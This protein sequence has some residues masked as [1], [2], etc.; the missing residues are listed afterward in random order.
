MFLDNLHYSGI[1]NLLPAK[2]EF[3]STL[4]LFW[5]KNGAGKTSFLEAVHLLATGKSFRANA[6]QEYLS[7]NEE[8]CLLSGI[9][10]TFNTNL[11]SVRL[12]IERFRDG[13][14]TLRIAEEK[15]GSLAEFARVLAV[16][17]MSGDSYRLFDELPVRRRRFMDWGMF[18][19]E[20]SFFSHWQRYH[21]AL[22]QRNRALKTFGKRVSEVKAWDEILI[23]SGESLHESRKRF[24]SRFFSIFEQRLPDFLNIGTPSIQYRKGWAKGE[25]LGKALEASL[26]RDQALGYTT[27][28]P[29][30]ADFEILL[31]EQPV[32]AIL[33][34]GQKKL[35]IAALYLVRAQWFS[36][37]KGQRCVMLVDDLSAE[38]D[39]ETSDALFQGLIDLG[40]QAFI[41][42]V[43]GTPLLDRLRGGPYPM[44]HVEHGRIG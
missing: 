25:G 27:V 33:S 2:L 31:D 29:H 7:F 18:H 14:H 28:G 1:R 36:E 39:T 20:H 42:V 13:T 43:E 22:K 11:P 15:C 3:S 23:E 35:L 19:V 5:G 17:F 9:I 16:Q 41:A 4:N 8:S 38:L 21:S 32:K 26:F 34:R 6:V 30:R 40:G 44:F 12:G 10:N 37:E 24:I